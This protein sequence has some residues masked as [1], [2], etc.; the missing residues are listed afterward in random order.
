M[1]LW[2]PVLAAAAL[3]FSV[4]SAW[5]VC[6]GIDVLI[7]DK[8]ETL[9]PTWGEPTA[10]FRAE[11]GQLV[12]SPKA[13]QYFWTANTAGLYDDIDMCVT[14]TTVTGIEPTEAKAGVIFWF[15]DDNNFYVFEIAPN[16]KASVWRR[17]RG[18]WLAQVNW[19]DAPGA[20]EGDGASNELRVTT[21]DS[22][23]TFYV[24][25]Q[26]FATLQG[27]PPQR[28][29]QI[30]LFATSPAAGAAEYA[31]DDLRVTKP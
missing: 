7:E 10:A 28:G 24:N 11:D 19:R 21:V 23:A 30:G 16:G 2:R 6:P 25:G 13:D 9:Q 1:R 8:F 22:D 5:A 12:V 4:G 29:Q 18:K 15:D 27:T 17:Q 20:T 31:F 3:V 26:E 14:V